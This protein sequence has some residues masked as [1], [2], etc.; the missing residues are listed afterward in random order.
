V[1]IPKSAERPTF[2]TELVI[3]TNV[4]ISDVRRGVVTTQ[5]IVSDV[6]QGVTNTHAVV[7]ELQQDFASTQAILSD[8]HAMVKSQGGTTEGN[9][10][11]V[12]LARSGLFRISAEVLLLRFKTGR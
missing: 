6:Q 12:S 10:Q 7:S 11:P 8:V 1:T 3:N 9:D 2:Q 5:T 4:T